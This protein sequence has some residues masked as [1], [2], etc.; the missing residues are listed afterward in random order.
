M[1]NYNTIREKFKSLFLNELLVDD[2]WSA[3]IDLLLRNIDVTFL[4]F[5]RTNGFPYEVH[6]S[7]YVKRQEGTPPTFSSEVFDVE[8]LNGVV[9]LTYPKSA[10]S[11]RLD[12]GDV[13]VA[14]NTEGLIRLSV[15]DGEAW[16][17]LYFYDASSDHTVGQ[18]V[19]ELTPDTS[20][21]IEYEDLLED[22][23]VFDLYTT[24]LYLP[25]QINPASI[26]YYKNYNLML[27][28]ED[29]S[30]TSPQALFG[31]VAQL[32]QGLR[33]YMVFN[34]A[35]GGGDRQKAFPRYVTLYDVVKTPAVDDV[36]AHISAI[37]SAKVPLDAL[38]DK[39][40]YGA[41]QAQ[42]LGYD[43][44]VL[45]VLDNNKDGTLIALQADPPQTAD[46]DIMVSPSSI[47]FPQHNYPEE[48]APPTLLVSNIYKIKAGPGWG[49]EFSI[50]TNDPKAEETQLGY[51]SDGKFILI[52]ALSPEAT[53][54][55]FGFSTAR[56]G[57]TFEFWA[58]SLPSEDS[59]FSPSVRV[60]VEAT[61]PSEMFPPTLTLEG[62][63][64]DTFSIKA[65]WTS[66]ESAATYE[67]YFKKS[68]GEFSLQGSYGASTTTVTFEVP[69]AGTYEVYVRALADGIPTVQSTTETVTLA[70]NQLD[71]PIISWN[72]LVFPQ[73][74]LTIYEVPNATAYRYRITWDGGSSEWIET[75]YGEIQ[76]AG[77]IHE[78]INT[79]E[80]YAVGS[81]TYGDSPV[82]S[83]QITGTKL[84]TPEVST[85]LDPEALSV[86]VSWPAVSGATSYLV[87]IDS[88]EPISTSET[89]YETE[90]GIGLHSVSVIAQSESAFDSDP[91]TAE[92]T[93]VSSGFTLSN[94]S[95]EFLQ[96]ATS[97]VV[98]VEVSGAYEGAWNVEGASDVQ[99]R[100]MA[101]QKAAARSATPESTAQVLVTT[102]PPQG[103][104]PIL[105]EV[106][107]PTPDH[108][109]L[110][111]QLGDGYALLCSPESILY[112]TLY[113]ITKN[114]DMLSLDKG[115]LLSVDLYIEE[116]RSNVQQIYGD[117]F[118]ALL[119]ALEDLLAKFVPIGVGFSV[120]FVY[121]MIESK[122]S[123]SDNYLGVSDA[124]YI[125]GKSGTTTI[126]LPNRKSAYQF[127]ID[128]NP[129]T[130][131]WSIQDSVDE[132]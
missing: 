72:L 51:V 28:N 16:Q 82:V 105:S 2:G 81:A 15:K 122:L 52:Q 88:E 69:E 116:L 78:G 70:E 121:P 114:Y 44:N 73:T 49:F 95:L 100:M 111:A 3:F 11:P 90:V 75:A 38:R 109:Y 119:K 58:I 117:R 120:N 56:A 21:Q 53:Y 47:E 99:A 112:E 43:K 6:F 60:L 24:L 76:N 37:T 74:T 84:Q 79:V 57:D 125:N 35:D 101:T 61:V 19:I 65:T 54:F 97:G 23:T 108:K 132:N 107:Q 71:S 17:E 5:C 131:G 77:E 13:T 106:T 92:F 7:D 128:T 10:T 118:E 115:K 104:T 40:G 66:V 26:Q 63:V 41:Q 124:I 39:F 110:V 1:S 12:F 94:P 62:I 102:N 98:G 31:A 127:N 123:I 29:T 25:E 34:T 96:R 33:F 126:S 20:F 8:Y 83:A 42:I 91:G 59:G 22:G 55:S 80:V 32:L 85:S 46:A 50:K 67:V 45:V 48:L 18:P 87:Q 30:A 14:L 4:Q 93:M 36:P 130:L 129:A 68:D 103:F 9:T 86:V 113:G 27:V 89:S 64:Q